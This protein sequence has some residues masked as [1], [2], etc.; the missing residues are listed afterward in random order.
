[1]IKFLKFIGIL[2][3]IAAVFY[4]SAMCGYAFV[5]P[6]TYVNL[7]ANTSVVYSLNVYNIVIDSSSPDEKGDNVV[8]CADFNYKKITEVI[9][10]TIDMLI[11]EGCISSEN[12]SNI[13]ITVKNS[14]NAKTERLVKKLQSSMQNYI[15]GKPEIK[16]VYVNSAAQ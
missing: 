14:D 4:V 6:V 11:S 12:K 10:K 5:V 8:C 15:I 1:M 16:N 2:F 13:K 3:F 7:D 9:P